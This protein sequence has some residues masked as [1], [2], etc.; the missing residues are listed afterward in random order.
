MIAS[1]PARRFFFILLAAVS[2]LFAVVAR[3]IASALFLAAVLA[4]VLW[5][6]HLWLSAR[7]RGRRGVSAGALAVGVMMILV[8][9]IVT[10]SAFAIQEGS[11][12]VRFLSQTVRSEGVIGLVDRLP[13]TLRGWAKKGLERI[14][15]EGDKSLSDGLQEQIRAHGGKAAAAVG[16]TL[17]ATGAFLFQVAMMLI[18]LFFLLIEGDKLVAWLDA[19]SPLPAGQTHEL[20]IEFKRVSFAVLLSAVLTSGVQAVAALI[21]FFVAHVPHPIFF[22]GVTF[23]VAFIPAVGA[24]SVCLVAAAL[25]LAMGHPYAALFLSLWGLL[26]VGLVDNLVKPLLIK[27]GMRMNGAVVFFALIGGLSAFGGVGLLLGPLVVALFLSLLRI[28]QRDYRSRA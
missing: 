27:I 28:Y 21:G 4:G 26:V 12:G 20:L 13:P 25:L 22:A 19:L 2:I 15:P 24:A 11:D 6:L 23:F 1:Q 8:V 10:F 3:P 7:L 9:P 18:A 14:S 17:S 5:P 16:A